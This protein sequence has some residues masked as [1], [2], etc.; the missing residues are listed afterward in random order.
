VTDP[1]PHS[2]GYVGHVSFDIRDAERS[3]DETGPQLREAVSCSLRLPITRDFDMTF[4]RF[5][6]GDNGWPAILAAPQPVSFTYSVAVRLRLSSHGN[7]VSKAYFSAV[8]THGR[9]R[10][11]AMFATPPAHRKRHR[12]VLIPPWTEI[13]F[14]GL[15]EPTADPLV[16]NVSLQ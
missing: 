13:R 12:G 16:F 3:S 4:D 2:V 1:K 14:K 7:R 11:H 5:V 10:A 8:E 6:V 9:E 15:V